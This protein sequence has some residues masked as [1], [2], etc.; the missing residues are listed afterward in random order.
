MDAPLGFVWLCDAAD[1]VGRKIFGSSWRPISTANDCDA[2]VREYDAFRAFRPIS[3][4][5]G[6]H[7]RA[8]RGRCPSTADDHDAHVRDRDAFR[9]SR[10][11][12]ADRNHVISLIAE[13][14]EAGEIATGYRSLAGADDLD[15]GVWR[16]PCW[17][18]Y[19]E[20]GTI[21]LDL[22]LLDEKNRPNANGYTVRCTRE[23]FVRRLD[24][25]R[26]VAALPGPPLAHT[27]LR[28]ASDEPLIREALQALADSKVKGPLQAAKL[29]YSKAQGPSPNANLD[30]L[31]KSIAF[32]WNSSPKIAKS[33]PTT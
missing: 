24:L 7:V 22:P 19:F 14:C 32:E 23:I 6:A 16:L 1:M 26:F 30:R 21:N 10:N 11:L 4:D 28:H 12:D 9:A 25:E 27:N 20:T 5:Y 2:H 3:Y 17:R 18:A 29:V 33:S 8:F 31:R 13:Q 15:R